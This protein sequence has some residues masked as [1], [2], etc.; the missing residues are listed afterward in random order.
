[1]AL[2]R[3][4]VL[5]PTDWHVRRRSRKPRNVHHP[6]L[7]RRIATRG[8]KTTRADQYW[9]GAAAATIV[10]PHSRLCLGSRRYFCSPRRY[11]FQSAAAAHSRAAFGGWRSGGELA[12]RPVPGREKRIRGAPP[13]IGRMEGLVNNLPQPRDRHLLLGF[14]QRSEPSVLPSSSRYQG[15]KFPSTRAA[16][17]PLRRSARHAPYRSQP[18]ERRRQNAA[19]RRRSR[20]GAR[21]CPGLYETCVVSPVLAPT[22]S[23]TRG[24]PVVDT[25]RGTRY[26]AKSGEA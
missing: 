25:W 5:L 14:W 24:A 12:P 16:M 8:R 7:T 15:P 9:S 3:T 1:M 18:P 4:T 6:R 17:R 13:S 19:R 11:G 23:V 10:R 2:A 26:P 21:S 22:A 20:P